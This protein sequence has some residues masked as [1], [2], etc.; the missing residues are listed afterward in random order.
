MR[1]LNK[2]EMME[3]NGGTADKE[4]ERSGAGG[5]IDALG[6]AFSSFTGMI[7]SWF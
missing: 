4:K 7:S 5:F 6:N 3:I 1:D 2:E